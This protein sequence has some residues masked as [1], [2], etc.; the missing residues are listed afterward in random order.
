MNLFHVMVHKYGVNLHINVQIQLKTLKD[1]IWR[2]KLFS[3]QGYKTSK[4]HIIL[5]PSTNIK[6]MDGIWAQ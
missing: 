5:N 4:V 6:I 3:N 2:G 1:I